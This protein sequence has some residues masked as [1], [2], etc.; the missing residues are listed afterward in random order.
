MYSS[1]VSSCFL[2]MLRAK[3]QKLHLWQTLHSFALI[4][5]LQRKEITSQYCS[6]EKCCHLL[7]VFSSKN[8]HSLCALLFH[9]PGKYVASA[10]FALVMPTSH[11]RFAITAL[12]SSVKYSC[13]PRDPD[14]FLDSSGPMLFFAA[15]MPSGLGKTAFESSLLK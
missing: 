1:M 7:F 2:S 14:S 6:T 5:Q 10:R 11:A 9:C 8:F 15:C 4:Y 3:T 13:R 12:Y